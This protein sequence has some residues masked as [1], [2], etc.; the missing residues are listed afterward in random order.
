M[1]FRTKNR[2]KRITAFVVFGTIFFVAI[3]YLVM[4]LWNG[5]IPEIFSSMPEIT[6]WQAVGLLI[7]TRI[8]FTGFRPGGY[9]RRGAWRNKWMEMSEEER[10]EL[11]RKWK[12]RCEKK[13]T[14][15]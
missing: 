2:V 12:E 6:F 8:L 10:E 3:G 5:L 7:L 11:K 14:P 9:R 1:M 15:D 13:E 4:V